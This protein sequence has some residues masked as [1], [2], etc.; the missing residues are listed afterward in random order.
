MKGNLSECIK[1]HPNI[2]ILR[3][4]C[5][6]ISKSRIFFICDGQKNFLVAPEI[7]PL[8]IHIKSLKLL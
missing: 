8:V 2:S 7:I 5:N 1:I 6:I 3:S 4:K